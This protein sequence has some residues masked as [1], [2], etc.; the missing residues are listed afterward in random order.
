MASKNSVP[1]KEFRISGFPDFRISDFSG[2]RIS[3]FRDFRISDL[4]R[5]DSKTHPGA[6]PENRNK[7]DLTMPLKKSFRAKKVK[8]RFFF[9]GGKGGG[10][11]KPPFLLEK[12]SFLG[13]VITIFRF[14]W[15]SF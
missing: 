6:E 5:F 15:V 2:F 1:L 3:D 7:G 8:R 4:C 11:A 10:G 9:G 14:S 13:L 12:F